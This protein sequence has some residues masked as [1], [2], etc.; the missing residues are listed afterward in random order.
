MLRYWFEAN[1]SRPISSLKAA[2]SFLL[3]NMPI[4]LF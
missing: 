3:I 1:S 4:P 2:F